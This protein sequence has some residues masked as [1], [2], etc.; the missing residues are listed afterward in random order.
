MLAY[1]C[2]RCAIKVELDPDSK[3][4]LHGWKRLIVTDIAHDWDKGVENEENRIEKHL[5]PA[6]YTRIYEF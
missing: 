2:D 3:E 6:C 5:C 4:L 1:I